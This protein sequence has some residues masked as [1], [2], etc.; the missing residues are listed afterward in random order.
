MGRL[1]A[2][3]EIESDASGDVTMIRE[4]RAGRHSLSALL[5]VEGNEA[6]VLKLL[7]AQTQ[8]GKDGRTDG[9]KEMVPW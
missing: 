8:K 1:L 2:E 7:A 5:V 6:S 4:G 9:R 3:R